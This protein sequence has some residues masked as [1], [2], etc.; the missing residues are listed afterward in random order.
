VNR[1]QIAGIFNNNNGTTINRRPAGMPVADA[2][3]VSC[4][5][6]SI[7]LAMVGQQAG[8]IHPR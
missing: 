1:I 4:L 5:S 3:Q 8:K 2:G 6:W 7:L